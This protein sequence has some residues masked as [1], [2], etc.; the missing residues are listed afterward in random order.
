MQPM[1]PS[2][3]MLIPIT[4]LIPLLISPVISHQS[5]TVLLIINVLFIEPFFLFYLA[6]FPIMLLDLKSSKLM[7]REGLKLNWKKYLLFHNVLTSN[8]LMPDTLS[9]AQWNFDWFK[10]KAQTMSWVVWNEVN[11]FGV[12]RI[13]LGLI[14]TGCLRLAIRLS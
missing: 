2:L 5:S 13:T 6:Q 3:E 7:E 1:L 14:C 11:I 8:W 10:G 9:W 12:W 4:P